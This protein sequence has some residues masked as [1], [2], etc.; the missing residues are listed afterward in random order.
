MKGVVEKCTFCEE[1]ISSNRL[2]A[3]VEACPHGALVFGNLGDP[4]SDV[5]KILA[6]EYTIRR[7]PN[8]G[9]NPEVFYVV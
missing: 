5:S 1:R 8:L 7:K 2:P 6:A 3:C 4:N 9:T